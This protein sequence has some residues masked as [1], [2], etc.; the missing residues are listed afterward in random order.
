MSEKIHL[1][2]GERITV[3][4]IDCQID[5]AADKGS[6]FE[7]Y[8]KPGSQLSIPDG[9]SLYVLGGHENMLNLS[10]MIRRLKRRIGKLVMTLDSHQ[11]VHIAHPLMYVGRDG[12]PPPFFTQITVE[13]IEQGVWRAAHPQVIVPGRFIDAQGNPVATAAEGRPMNLQEYILFYTKELRRLDRNDLAIWPPHCHVGSVGTALHPAVEAACREWEEQFRRVDFQPKGNNPWTENYS[14]AMADVP[15]PLDQATRLNKR[16]VKL[17]EGDDP[18]DQGLVAWAGLA[19]FHC[20]GSTFVDIVRAFARTEAI[21]RMVLLDD[22]TSPVPG[23]KTRNDNWI[24]EMKVLGL[25][26]INSTDIIA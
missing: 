5:F 9:G 13:D 6:V 24:E 14:A 11:T 10:E 23:V 8:G 3:I 1:R 4:G 15:D 16:L 7:L 2:R 12:N 19:K 26:V 18:N 22:C 20:L 25:R 17:V 21:K